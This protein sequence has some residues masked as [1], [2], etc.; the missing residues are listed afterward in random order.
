MKRSLRSWLW[1]VPVDQEVDEE[2]EFHVAM[3]TRELVSQG[4]H[5]DAARRAAL[6]RLGDM[7]DIKRQ[8]AGLGRKRDRDM[9]VR[10]WIDE[11][12]HDVTYALRQLRRA[13][14]FTLVAALT[15]ALGIGANGAIFSLVDAALLQPLPFH[16]PDRL[17]MLWTRTPDTPRRAVSPL[18]MADWH[19]RTRS[20]DAIGGYVPSV[21]GMVI[22][23]ADGS[24]ETISRQWVSARFFEVLGVQAIVGRT[25]QQSDN[26]AG[27]DAVVLS[28]ALWRSRFNADPALVGR[29]IRLDGEPYTVV[30]VAPK[31][32]QWPGDA[33]MWGL[34][35]FPNDPRA[36]RPSVF[37]VIGRMKPDVSIDTARA[38]LTAVAGG[39]A[40]EFPATNRDRGI[41]L[42]PL[43]N[44]I[45]GADLRRTS[46]LFIGVVGVVLLICCGNVASLLLARATTRSRELAVRSALGA[47]RRRIIRQLMTESLVL[48]AIGGALALGIG[49]A[50]LNAAPSLVPAG[51]L[52]TTVSLAFDARVIGFCALM[53]LVVGL[54]FGIAPAWQ[55]TRRSASPTMT[56]DT[57]TGTGRGGGLRNAL[58]VAEIA[59]AVVL[60][61]GAGL[62]LRTLIAV[63]TVD[64]GYRANEVLTMMVDPIGSRY[65]TPAAL[66]QF[67]DAIEDEVRA[68]P[69]IRDVAWSTTVPLGQSDATRFSFEIVGDAPVDVAKQPSAYQDIASAAYFSTLD[70][71]VVA[72]RAFND[73]DT[74]ENVPVCIVSEALVRQHLQGRTAI[75]VRLALRP[76]NAPD[77]RPVV[78]EIVGVA[79][80][81]KARPDETADLLQIYVPIRQ[82]ITDDIF[83]LVRPAS[84][85]ARAVAPAVRAA[86]GRI[87]KEQLV[88]VRDVMTLED[89]AWTA[90]G[91]YRF[92]AVLVMTFAGLALLLA[93]VGVFGILAYTVQQRVREIGVR[94][95]LG[96]TSAEVLRLVAT[97]GGR[98][99]GTGAVIGLLLSVGT[100]RLL[101]TM[102]FG[103][104]P[105]DLV[106]FAA[107]ATT[108]L[109]TAAAA[110]AAPAWRAVRI[111]P[112]VAL[113]GD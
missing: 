61:F 86:I 66:L 47:G 54:V 102:L 4:M 35:S 7:R 46:L 53:A 72:G 101:T 58:V 67:Y 104:Q 49:A 9:R 45:I 23:G 71:P 17:V 1:R 75:G 33:S 55:A 74:R 37:A 111:D 32:F 19:S 59:T 12:R 97:S 28:E 30:G 87:D 92:R 70:L 62:L 113:R 16:H 110:M 40:A 91:N 11:F 65:P 56:P 90:T 26:D 29:T 95:A 94:R 77:A 51:V 107:V 27:A 60:L 21:G 112:A 106:T 64:R 6:A 44:A 31:E 93:M 3:R 79:R 10:Q 13:P 22:A 99:I 68:L 100:A 14:G 98:V 34:I 69:G 36:R 78:R 38:D 2:V 41:T 76:A 80:Q 84:G 50:I 89:V 57:R 18:D 105:F 15:L 83:L 42:E 52:P 43:H 81:L 88:S 63:D 25:F 39:L 103:V 96:A 85:P 24:A 20:F 82:L 8:C 109:V 5:P 108:L 73:R 48:S